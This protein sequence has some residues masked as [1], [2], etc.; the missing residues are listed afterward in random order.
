MHV[1]ESPQHLGLK[2]LALIWAREQGFR[3]A[4]TEVSLPHFGVRLDAAACRPLK[5]SRMAGQSAV[6]AAVGTTAIFECKQTR[7]DFIRDSRC[8]EKLSARLRSLAERR[9]LYEES[10]R[11]YFPSLRC[12]DALF[13]EFD[14]FRFE[15]AGFEPYDKICAEMKR[16]SNWLHQQTKF[17]DLLRWRTANLHYIVSEEGVARPYELP[18][19]WG[20]LL[21][22]GDELRVVTPAL[23]QQVPPEN[24][25]QLLLRI[26]VSGTRMTHRAFAITAPS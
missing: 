13:P 24:G 7:A 20:L 3:I 14:G 26:A 22:D 25:F 5:M 9:R 21:R 17:A 8:A 4:A 1:A 19:G 11:V 10:M 23:W 12:S 16:L 18:L 6:S 2:R 15:T